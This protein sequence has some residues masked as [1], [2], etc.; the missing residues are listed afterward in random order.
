MHNLTLRVIRDEHASLAAMLQSLAMMLKMGPGNHPENYF[1]V[2]RAMLFYIEEIPEQQHHPIE[3]SVLFPKVAERVPE[4]RE[5]IA[6]LDVEHEKGE[7][8]VLRLQHALMAWEL[9]GEDRR[10]AFESSLAEYIGF[11][12]A[13][14]RLEEE[15]VLPAAQRSLEAA[16]WAE[17]D[18]VFARNYD[19]LGR[20]L[21]G[22]SPST[23]DPA[24]QHL[25]TRI[26]TLAPPP[27]G[28]GQE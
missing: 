14:M 22:K 27:V 5:A 25:C 19:P 24:Y 12:E 16:D 28:M 13:H 15:V 6:R 18:A 26:A 17:V 3:S 11:Y 10:A 2:M 4:V 9:L 21:A 23:L 8:A 20:L 1:E 7:D